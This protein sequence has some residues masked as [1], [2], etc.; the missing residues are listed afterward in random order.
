MFTNGNPRDVLARIV[1]TL[2]LATITGLALFA[3]AD[4]A[5]KGLI[6]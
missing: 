5:T 1:I 2:G 6:V 4:F 3:T